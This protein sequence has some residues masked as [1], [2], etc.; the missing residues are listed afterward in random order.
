MYRRHGTQLYR[1]YGF[2]DSFNET[3]NVPVTTQHGAVIRGIGW[4]NTDYLG[5]DQGPIVIMI[6][7]HRSGLVWEMMKKN[8]YIRHGLQRAG[9]TGGWLDAK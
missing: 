5:I 2:I 4:F 9:F 8:P 6:E 7:N 3:L 1:K